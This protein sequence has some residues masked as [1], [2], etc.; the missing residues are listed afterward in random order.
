M[1]QA[2]PE[3]CS[4]RLAHRC[5]SPDHIKG[6]WCRRD[7]PGERQIIMAI[8]NPEHFVMSQVGILQV[9]LRCDEAQWDD[10]WLAQL[11]RQHM[12]V[13]KSDAA[14]AWY[15]VGVRSHSVAMME[16]QCDDLGPEGGLVW[17][18]DPR[19][20]AMH[21]W[22]HRDRG[23]ELPHAGGVPHNSCKMQALVGGTHSLVAFE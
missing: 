18:L 1:S 2:I 20:D 14:S 3:P 19:S 22:G 15:I 8:N 5:Q 11:L 6:D 21:N 23:T 13:S 12:V 7:I 4:P 16:L 17:H 10:L 9:V